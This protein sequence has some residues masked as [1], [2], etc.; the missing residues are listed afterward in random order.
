[1]IL[2]FSDI[3]SIDAAKEMAINVY[4]CPACFTLARENVWDY[5]GIMWIDGDAVPADDGVS[6][7]GFAAMPNPPHWRDVPEDL[8][9]W[10]VV[11]DA[12][13]RGSWEGVSRAPYSAW[14]AAAN[15]VAEVVATR[16]ARNGNR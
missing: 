6:E 2:A 1:M 3:K 11:R 5:P 13:E 14:E 7:V 12:V 8:P 10:Q 15:A 16:M 9:L 4:K